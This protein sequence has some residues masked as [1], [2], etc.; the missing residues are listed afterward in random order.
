MN[1]SNQK[2][3]QRKH[4]LESIVLNTFEE[5]AHQDRSTIAYVLAGA[6]I[7]PARDNKAYFIVAEDVLAMERQGKLVQE[8]G[9]YVLD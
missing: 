8:Q 3:G 1:G 9:W 4:A 2:R 6:F 7:R 5:N